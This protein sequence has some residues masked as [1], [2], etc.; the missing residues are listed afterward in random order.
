MRKAYS[1]EVCR[2]LEDKFRCAR[3]YRPMKIEC[4]DVGQKLV[5]EVEEV[6]GNGRGRVRAIVEKFV[7]G[8][9]AGQ[10]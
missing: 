8:G 7:G 4:Y 3:L 10:V 2:K 5:Y 6:A 1:V 9:C